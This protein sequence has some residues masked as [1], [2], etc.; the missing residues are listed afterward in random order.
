MTFDRLQQQIIKAITSEDPQF[1]KKD[2]CKNLP[3]ING[4]GGFSIYR[5][6]YREQLRDQIEKDFPDSI[7]LIGEK[8]FDNLFSNFIHNLSSNPWNINGFN[9]LWSQYI[10]NSNES[11]KIKELTNWEWLKVESYFKHYRKTQPIYPKVELSSKKGLSVRLDDSVITHSFDFDFESED[12]EEAHGSNYVIWTKRFTT[13]SFILSEIEFKLLL[14][15]SKHSQLDSI[16]KDLSTLN[17]DE[18][19][20][21]ESFQSTL[22]LF[23]EKGILT[24]V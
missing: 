22:D 6:N 4:L 17:Y 18:A 23:L 8:K 20:L 7:E 1:E 12:L 13:C 16:I 5:V 11:H 9:A 2:W 3:I 15:M 24:N 19:F 21:A 10:L 14:S